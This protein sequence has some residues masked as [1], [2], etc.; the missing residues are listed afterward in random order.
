MHSEPFTGFAIDSRRQQMH[1]S[2]SELLEELLVSSNVASGLHPKKHPVRP[3]KKAAAA[4]S[5]ANPDA[6][7]L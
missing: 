7:D 4:N 3:S 6:F 5:A 1:L 2:G